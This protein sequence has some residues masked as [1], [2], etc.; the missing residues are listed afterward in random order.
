MA[1][2]LALVGCLGC[3]PAADESTESSAGT[4]SADTG[5]STGEDTSSEGS[6]DGSSEEG[7]TG[8]TSGDVAD[9]DL[10]CDEDEPLLQPSGAPSGLAWCDGSL[11]HRAESVTCEVPEPP[12][13]CESAGPMGSC[14]TSAECTD[15]PFGACLDLGAIDQG[16]QCTYAC[17]TDADCESGSVCTCL[18]GRPQCVPGECGTDADCDGLCVLDTVTD[19]CGTTT[20]TL[21]CLDPDH[22]CRP[23]IAETCPLGACDENTE[24]RPCA[25][26]PDGYACGELDCGPSGCG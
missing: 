6:A 3:G 8:G 19:E 5:S 20:H 18:E 2:G 21:R 1:G 13:T 24:R 15:G 14:S 9:W 25:P 7:S 22:E 16:C 23:D 17:E 26:G 12:A 10:A 4:E 11:P